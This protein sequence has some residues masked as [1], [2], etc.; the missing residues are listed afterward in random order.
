[1]YSGLLNA[2]AGFL[3]KMRV[4]RNGQKELA[5]TIIILLPVVVWQQ[6]PMFEKLKSPLGWKSSGPYAHWSQA[7]DDFETSGQNLKVI[8]TGDSESDSKHWGRIIENQ[9]ED[10]KLESCLSTGKCADYQ[11]DALSDLEPVRPVTID[12]LNQRRT[13]SI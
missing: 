5:I 1:M 3:R 11:G 9:T 4:V 13:C 12:D 8:W 2:W 10:C 7:Y 6:R